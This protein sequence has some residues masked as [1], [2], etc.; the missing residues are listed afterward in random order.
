M[1]NNIKNKILLLFLLLATVSFLPCFLEIILFNNIFNNPI[2][3]LSVVIMPIIIL[4]LLY[5][6]SVKKFIN[7]YP[8]ITLSI[9]I[10]LSLLIIALEA[11][12]GYIWYSIIETMPV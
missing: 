8:K 5:F 6:M 2:G 10:T 7:K 4:I 1:Q 12:L 3:A 9:F 11:L